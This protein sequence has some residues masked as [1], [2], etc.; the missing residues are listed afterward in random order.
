MDPNQGCPCD[1][2][3]V[4]CNFTAGG[5]TCIDPLK[6]QVHLIFSEQVEKNSV[7]FCNYYE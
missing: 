6:S 5:T 1:A 4:L 2:V 7:T 3:K